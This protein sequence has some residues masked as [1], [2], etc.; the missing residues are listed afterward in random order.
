LCL[1]PT[2]KE[3]HINFARLPCCCTFKKNDPLNICMFEVY[4]Y[5]TFVDC[6]LRD[7]NVATPRILQCIILVLLKL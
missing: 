3:L 1:S 6:S 7:T 2:N 5:T 4:Q